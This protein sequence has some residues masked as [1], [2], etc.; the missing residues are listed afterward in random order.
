MNDQGGVDFADVVP[1]YVPPGSG[2]WQRARGPVIEVYADGAIDCHCDNCGAEPNSFCRHPRRRPHDSLCDTD[3]RRRRM[4][5]AER[6]RRREIR[7]SAEH[8][9]EQHV[10]KTAVLDLRTIRRAIDRG[11]DL[12]LIVQDEAGVWQPRLPDGVQSADADPRAW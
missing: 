4:N 10:A 1:V 8:R 5:R 12:G 11:A 7:T 9:Q 2:R 3:R 6:R